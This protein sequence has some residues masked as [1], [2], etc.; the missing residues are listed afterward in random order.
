M[1]DRQEGFDLAEKVKSTIKGIK[2][3]RVTPDEY[4]KSDC[5]WMEAERIQDLWEKAYNLLTTDEQKRELFEEIDDA[6]FHLFVIWIVRQ[7]YMTSK[8]QKQG[9]AVEWTAEML[10]ELKQEVAGLLRD[11][12]QETL[13]ERG[14]PWQKGSLDSLDNG[15]LC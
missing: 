3:V 10:E 2:F 8:Y 13:I 5:I 1:E 4:A 7:A 6:V 11:H 12:F 9:V 14:I 15:W